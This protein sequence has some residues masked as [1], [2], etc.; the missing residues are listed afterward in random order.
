[1]SHDHADTSVSAIDAELAA[2]DTAEEE[3]LVTD[4]TT[5]DGHRTVI[6]GGTGHGSA[7]ARHL[8]VIQKLPPRDNLKPAERMRL[9]DSDI[10]EAMVLVARRIDAEAQKYS[11]QGFTW[12][13]EDIVYDM[14]APRTVV[15]TLRIAR[16]GS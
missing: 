13:L 5:S 4:V 16:D 2:M 10:R 1:M 12:D 8:V 15:A 7:N 6:T 14:G 9:L 11:V 3:A